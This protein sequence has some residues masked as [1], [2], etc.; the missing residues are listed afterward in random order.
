MFVAEEKKRSKKSA[1]KA[2]VKKFV[3]KK[4]LAKA[5]FVKKKGKK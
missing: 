1:M 2:L 5:K 3:P 4:T